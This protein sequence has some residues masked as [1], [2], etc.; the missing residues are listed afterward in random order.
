MVRKPRGLGGRR[1]LIRVGWLADSSS[2]LSKARL[3]AASAAAR[4]FSLP[5]VFVMLMLR[6]RV[7]RWRSRYLPTE[8]GWM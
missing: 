3:R 6:L 1:V 8:D 5:P 7:L 4:P 2:M